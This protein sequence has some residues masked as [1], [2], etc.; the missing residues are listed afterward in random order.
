[1]YGCIPVV[2]QD[3]VTQPF[4]DDLEY[5]AF[6]LRVKESDIDRL[7]DILNAVTDAQVLLGFRV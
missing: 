3:E 2:I 1:L 6:S 5:S 7:P 4:E